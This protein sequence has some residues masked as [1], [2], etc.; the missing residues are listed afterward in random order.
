M[1]YQITSQTQTN[2]TWKS[3][4]SYELHLNIVRGKQFLTKTESVILFQ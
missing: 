1:E 2:E 4:H 3:L